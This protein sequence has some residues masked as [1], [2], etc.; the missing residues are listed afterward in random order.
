MTT[1]NSHII[2][3]LNPTTH[4]VTGTIACTGRAYYD[5]H[6]HTSIYLRKVTCPDCLRKS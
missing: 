2:H 3:K 1:S 6:V 4:K 5:E